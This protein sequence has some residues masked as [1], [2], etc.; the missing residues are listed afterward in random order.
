M[1]NVD[2]QTDIP[3]IDIA[4]LQQLFQILNNRCSILFSSLN[5]FLVSFLRFQ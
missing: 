3:Q 2:R 5:G 4:F 1:G